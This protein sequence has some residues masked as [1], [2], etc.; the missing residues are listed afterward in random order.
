MSDNPH[1]YLPDGLPI[2]I[3]LDGKIAAKDLW[4]GKLGKALD[5]VLGRA[6]K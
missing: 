6:D 4:R 1:I 5:E 3:G 2:L